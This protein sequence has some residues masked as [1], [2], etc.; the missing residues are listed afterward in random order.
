M[1][2]R[3]RK[4]E[5]SAL[6]GPVES[7]REDE[8][9]EDD[10]GIEILEVVGVDETTGSDSA[11]PTPPR[12]GDDRPAAS[13]P[14]GQDGE[15]DALQEALSEKDR[16]HDLFLRKQA[17]F[18]NFRKRI[19][20]ERGEA[21]SAAAAD[22]LRVILPVIDNLERALKTSEGSDDP[23]R[24][25]LVLIQQQFLELLKKEG[26]R[27]LETTGER[28]DPHLHEAVDVVD[29]EGFEQGVI[30]EEMR[31]GYMFRDK[32][33]RPTMVRVSSGRGE[34]KG[35]GGGPEKVS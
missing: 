17:E 9:R 7:V 23:L 29:V 12:R 26:L 5:E 27:P 22:L 14:S 15:P 2:S 31:R 34:P 21:R 24:Q 16:Y 4:G 1:S 8:P 19:A 33:L 25:G 32:L 11:K 13:A 35:E 18:E 30:L 10:D 6:T 28:F 20:R 3:G